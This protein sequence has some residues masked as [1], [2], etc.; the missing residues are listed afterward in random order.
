MQLF[1]LASI[2]VCASA[3]AQATPLF[4]ST[5]I[6]QPTTLSGVSDVGLLQK[7]NDGPVDP[8][9][10]LGPDT[11]KLATRQNN[12]IH[13]H[14]RLLQGQILNLAS[15]LALSVTSIR[16]T[17]SGVPVPAL[18]SVIDNR[19]D[20]LGAAVSVAALARSTGTYSLNTHYIG[21]LVAAW[22]SPTGVTP[23]L[24]SLEWSTL[25]VAM[26]RAQMAQSSLGDYIEVVFNIAG[27]S[28][29]LALGLLSLGG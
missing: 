21:T 20:S 9:A 13:R 11:K 3:I 14:T 24:T 29:E 12:I 23:Y 7:S 19:L 4:A 10:S 22:R 8:P 26:Y 1:V 25:F 28:F 6:S 17:G 2:L 18:D 15:G 16:Y 5:A 27:N